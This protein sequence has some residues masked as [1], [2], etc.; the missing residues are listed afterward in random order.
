MVTKK[1]LKAGMILAAAGVAVFLLFVDWEARAVKKHLRALEKE[2]TWAPGDNE[3]VMAS[4]IKSVQTMIAQTCQV[5]LPTYEIAQSVSKNDVPTYMMMGKNRYSH[6]SVK[7]HDLKV[8]SIDL[9]QA[10]AVATA[11]I[12]AT[13]ADNQKNDEVLVLEF[14]LQ[15]V[16]KKWQIVEAREIQVLEK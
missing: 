1:Y 13:G 10:R 8:E 12:K 9:P 7:L 6:L 11:Y 2:I 5:D 15:K 3:L 14:N 16:E 4:R